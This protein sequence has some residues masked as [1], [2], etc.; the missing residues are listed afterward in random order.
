MC[1]RL[2][3]GPVLHAVVLRIWIGPRDPDGVDGKRIREVDND[4]LR[5]QRVVFAGELFRQ[6]RITL[7]VGVL[8]A[9]SDTA[10][11]G[12][13]GSIVAGGTAMREGIAVRV[14]DEFRRGVA[15]CEV[16]LT[17]WIAPRAF[18]IPVP[19]LDVEFGVLPVRNRLPARA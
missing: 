1:D 3:T 12:G 17:H 2:L 15:A 8:V 14:A 18:R 19:G 10:V 11:A 4:P 9:V 6:I 7:P 16:S 13:I 5:V